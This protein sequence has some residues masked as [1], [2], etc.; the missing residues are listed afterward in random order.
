MKNTIWKFLCEYFDVFSLMI[1]L[2][3]NVNKITDTIDTI[4]S[5][6]EESQIE[7][8]KDIHKNKKDMIRNLE[9]R[10]SSKCMDILDTSHDDKANTYDHLNN[11]L[12]DIQ[13]TN[14]MEE[15]NNMMAQR[16][17]EF[18]NNYGDV[19]KF[20]E[21]VDEIE[22]DESKSKTAIDKEIDDKIELLQNTTT[23]YKPL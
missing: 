7:D 17:Q 8:P 21:A 18:I 23:D 4:L 12:L 9:I 19:E 6:Y 1:R 11:I 14:D 15:C 2:Q 13:S 10:L 20:K 16:K 22:Q 3:G 5:M